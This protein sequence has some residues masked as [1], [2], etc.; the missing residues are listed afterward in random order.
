VRRAAR[1]LLYLGAAGVV[2]GLGKY[3]AAYI[4]HYDFTN[5]FRFAW[6]LFYIVLLCLA[7][8][9]VGLPDLTRGSRSAVVSALPLLTAAGG[10][11]PAWRLN[12]FIA[13][14][15][16]SRRMASSAAIPASTM[17]STMG[18][19]SGLDGLST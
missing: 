19:S 7:A 16:P 2:L 4:G 15:M 11:L 9:A 18:R 13:G 17:A 3:H 1:L 14:S 8:Y 10:P 6:S 12:W 5:S